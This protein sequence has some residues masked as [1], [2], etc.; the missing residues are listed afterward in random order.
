MN[1]PD[2]SGELLVF[3]GHA[4][5]A[6]VQA[7]AVYALEH[8]V[9]KE[10]RRLRD[11]KAPIPFSS[12][13][14]WKWGQDASSKVGGQRTLIDPYIL[15]AHV[16][17]FVFK[18]HVG[19]VSWEEL[20]LC[21]TAEQRKMVL[22]LFPKR[23]SDPDRR[24]SDAVYAEEWADLVRK[25]TIELT[26]EWNAADPRC[27]RP[28][29]D[30]ND[31]DSL[32]QIAMERFKD[33]LTGLASTSPSILPEPLIAVESNDPRRYLTWL[34]KEC[35]SVEIRGLQVSGGKAHR[36]DIEDL[37]TPLYTVGGELEEK[38]DKRD[39]PDMRPRKVNLDEILTNKHTVVIGDPGS[40]KSTFLRHVTAILCR[41]LLGE[42]PE[43]AKEKLGLVKAPL[44][45][46]IRISELAA[47]II[48]CDDKKRP[49]APNHYN[50]AEWVIHYLADRSKTEEWDLSADFFRE[51]CKSGKAL[52]LFDGLDEAPGRNMRE[53]VS[54]I[55]EHAVRSYDTCTVIV[56][57]RPGAYVGR[58]VLDAFAH[59]T[60]A[61]LEEEGIRTFLHLW[62]KALHQDD[63]RKGREYAEE[64][65]RAVSAKPEIR[66]MAVNPVM[67]TALAVLYWND[68][69]LPDQRS[70]LY[71]SIIIW[72][73]RSRQYKADRILNEDLSRRAHQRL[74]F[75]MQDAA[76]GRK[77]SIDKA[78]AHKCVSTL[79]PGESV[80]DKLAN[81]VRF[82]E[83]EE[84]DSGIIVS[85]G[86]TVEFWHL[87]FQEFLAAKELSGMSD[88]EQEQALFENPDRTVHNPEWRETLLLFVGVMYKVG[89]GRLNAF[90][91][92]ML[93][94][95]ALAAQKAKAGDRLSVQARC[96]GLMGA[97]VRDLSVYS[98]TVEDSRY[99]T[100]RNDVM[101]I[102]D[103][104]RTSRIDVQTRC[105]AG[106]A[107]G[108]A[109]DPRIWEDLRDARARKEMFV[110]IPAGEFW[111]GSQTK[112]PTKK[113][114]DKDADS[115]ESPVERVTLGGY[116][117]GRYP[118]TV[119]QYQR[120]VD[121]SGY[122]KEEF[123]KAGGFGQGQSP[124]NWEQQTQYPN[125]PV[126]NVTWYE[127]MAFCAWAGLSLPTEAQWE[128]AARG[129]KAEYQKYPWGNESADKER[130]NIYE[131][132]IGHVS[133][134]GCFPAGNVV[135]DAGKDMWLADMA[136]NVREWTRS[137]FQPYPYRPGDGREGEY[138]ENDRF[139]LR[140]GAYY[141]G[142]RGVRCA[143]RD[144]IS[145][146]IR[147]ND[148]GFRVLA[149][150]FS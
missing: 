62:S 27:V 132:G 146:D 6:E 121:D 141:N 23:P 111:M 110:E 116:A 87:T 115:D 36:F 42:K 128:R 8:E 134:V 13:K 54:D 31:I 66:R 12:V 40:G 150:L 58:A 22:A 78:D 53:R 57:S 5:D 144:S 10:L 46:F 98:Y 148:V 99:L 139:V 20:N 68:K 93:D 113:N 43:A 26:K 94:K 30:Y 19:K 88:K 60:I 120:F 70:E 15:K 73:L 129:P 133:P 122:N 41:T 104:T 1:M 32:K 37:Y 135:W 109:G 86:T 142:V 49:D 76:G 35:G 85:R 119:A 14:F 45:L 47:H 7:K 97:M 140:G 123:W 131:T 50:A 83:D 52:F 4:A 25:K 9:Q 59:C 130:A 77:R 72:L 143:Y 63:E 126:M 64:L 11:A 2:Q 48:K 106:D 145:P 125:R 3:I 96:F 92:A 51:Q 24:D 17:V 101:G 107:L 102:F 103:A 89:T 105:A 114:Y 56:S 124:Q 79:M 147:D 38:K 136:G 21:C 75:E 149:S 81:G 90:F 34:G 127:S 69:R 80:R 71:E 28:C 108:Q 112:D 82:I 118:V 138:K 74:A 67:L 44:P 16:A 95:A 39:S 29:E 33:I 65:L 100:L 18:D 61:A 137:K 55:I 91:S 117:I 84:L